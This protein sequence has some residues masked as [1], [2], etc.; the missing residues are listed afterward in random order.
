MK[1]TK[2]VLEFDDNGEQLEF[3]AKNKEEFFNCMEF[4]YYKNKNVSKEDKIKIV[5]MEEV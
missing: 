4:Y 3:T 1:K 2:F 5:A